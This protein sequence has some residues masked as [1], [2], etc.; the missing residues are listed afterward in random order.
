MC[1]VQSRNS[2]KNNNQEIVPHC[3]ATFYFHECFQIQIHQININ[4]KKALCIYHNMHDIMRQLIA[5]KSMRRFTCIRY[6]WTNGYQ[7][8][9]VILYQTQVATDRLQT[10][11][12]RTHHAKFSTVAGT[13]PPS[14]QAPSLFASNQCQKCNNSPRHYPHLLSSEAFLR[15]HKL[16]PQKV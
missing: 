1:I 16:V 10:G 11:N 12:D 8:N 2:P 5:T 4:I 6:Y 15:T 9:G 3:L 14:H 7:N 13:I